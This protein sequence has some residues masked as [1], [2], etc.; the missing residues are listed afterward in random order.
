M[1]RRLF[2]VAAVALVLSGSPTVHAQATSVAPKYSVVMQISNP[3]PR[4]WN[5]ALSNSLALTKNAGRPNV[6]IRLVAIG[7]GLA[8]LK[9]GSPAEQRVAAALAQGVTVLACGET[10]TALA[11]E[12]DD[13]LPGVGVVPGGFIEVLDR[14]KEGWSYY[15][16]D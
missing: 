4:G 10:M 9:K 3:D 6:Q 1:K 15:K 11:L 13:L 16:A 2:A 14:Q 12:K 5:Q 7:A 8:M